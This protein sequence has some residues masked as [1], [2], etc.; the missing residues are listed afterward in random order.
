MGGIREETLRTCVVVGRR[1]ATSITVL[2][3]GIM[4]LANQALATSVTPISK[5]GLF[6]SR[7][8]V[9][10]RSQGRAVPRAGVEIEDTSRLLSKLRVARENPAPMTPGLDGILTQPPPQRRSP[11]LS[12]QTAFGDVAA[13]LGPRKAGEGLAE[14]LR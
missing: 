8:H 7:Q 13:N 2:V 6:I 3:T 4:L 12:H 9:V 14:A 11:D 1:L 10:G 5:S